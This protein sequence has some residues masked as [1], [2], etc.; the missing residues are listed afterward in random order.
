[1]RERRQESSH[2]RGALESNSSGVV[3]LRNIMPSGNWELG[4]A[5]LVGNSSRGGEQESKRRLTQGPL[6]G[7]RSVTYAGAARIVIEAEGLTGQISGME[8]RAQ[9]GNWTSVCWTYV[10]MFSANSRDKGNTVCAPSE[11]EVKTWRVK[12]VVVVD[13]PLPK[14][15]QD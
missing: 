13:L 9:H 2:S 6:A 7:Q 5:A 12:G 4:G 3:L 1:V 8:R 14:N 15:S 11:L 10:V